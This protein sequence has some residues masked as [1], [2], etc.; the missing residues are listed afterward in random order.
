MRAAVLVAII[1]AAAVAGAA[2]LESSSA[3]LRPTYYQ[4]VKPI[5]DGRCTGCH[6][7]GG[8]APFALTTY[9][10]ARRNRAAVAAV[11]SRRLMP[12]WHAEPGH[13]RYLYDPSLTTAQIATIARWAKLGGPR[14]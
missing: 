12:P 8:I 14:G 13:R 1:V 11:V 4:D 2:A 3:P 7:K 6:F 5:L 9:D 10:Q